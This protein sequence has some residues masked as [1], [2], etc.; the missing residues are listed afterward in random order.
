MFCMFCIGCFPGHSLGHRLASRNKSKTKY[1]CNFVSPAVA[2]H[3]AMNCKN[4]CLHCY[5]FHAVQMAN[6]SFK[7]P[8]IPAAFYY[9]LI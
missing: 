8:L 4:S 7:L 2:M 9:T 6:N 3:S 5:A 1:T